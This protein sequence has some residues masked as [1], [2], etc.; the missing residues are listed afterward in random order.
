MVEVLECSQV[1]LALTKWLI[2]EV[3]VH[4]LEHT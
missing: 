1:I 4:I 2:D 3:C